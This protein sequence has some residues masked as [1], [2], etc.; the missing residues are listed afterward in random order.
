MLAFLRRCQPATDTGLYTLVLTALVCAVYAPYLT[1][2]YVFDDLNLFNGITIY[3]YAAELWRN[4]PRWLSYA[5]LAHVQMLSGGSIAIQRLC[6]LLLHAANAMAVFVLLRDLLVARD[7]RNNQAVN[8]P[9]S[10]SRLAFLASALFAAHPVAVYGVGYLVQR[11]GELSAFF[12]L[13]ML[14]AYLRWLIAGRSALWMLS[15]FFYLLSVLSKEHSVAAPAVALLLTLV[16]RR[17]TLDLARRLVLPFAVYAAIAVAITLIVKGVLGAAYE[18]YAVDMLV[19]AQGVDAGQ[20]AHDAYFLSLITQAWLFFK[21]LFLWL[22]P[23]P[24]WMS[25]DMREPLASSLFSWPYW[26][27]AIAFGCYPVATAYMAMKGGRVGVAGWALAFPWLMFVTELSTARVQEP[28][29]LY[30]AYLWLPVFGVVVPLVLDRVRPW[31]ANVAVAVV[32]CALVPLS[33]N[34]LASLTDP[35]TAWND[36]AKLLVRGDEPGAGRIYYNRA[37]ALARKGHQ[38]E[39]LRDMD[40]AVALHPRLAQIRAAR[41]NILFRLKRYDEALQEIDVAIGVDA[42]RSDYYLSRAAILNRLGRVDE[43]LADARKSCEMGNVL[44]CAAQPAKRPR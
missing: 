40:R 13:L 23:D 35:L 1:N 19:Q 28:F 22:V 4:Q 24:A 2:A 10:A 32:V 20:A 29:V 42:G 9:A 11:S 37:Q 39:A 17:P 33:W 30:R 18:K 12:M 34:R 38:E 21:Y 36:A 25:I 3:D 31:A 15:A 8:D 41:A 14:I 6:N 5:T 43:A 26:V 7:E 44:A 16:L 27:A